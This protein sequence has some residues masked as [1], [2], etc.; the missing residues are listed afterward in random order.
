MTRMQQLTFQDA[1]YCCSEQN[2]TWGGFTHFVFCYLW[3]TASISKY[4]PA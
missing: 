4:P 1:L 3:Q 2:T